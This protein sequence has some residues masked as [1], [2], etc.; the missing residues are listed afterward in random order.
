MPSLAGLRFLALAEGA[1][2]PD[3]FT[4][5]DMQTSLLDRIGRDLGNL[6][7]RVEN[8]IKRL[9]G[10]DA[11]DRALHVMGGDLEHLAEHL[12]TW[13]MAQNPEPIFALNSS[14]MPLR[15]FAA[16]PSSLRATSLTPPTSLA[17]APLA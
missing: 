15:S 13:A 6:A 14:A 7:H 12:K 1:L 9:P 11:I 8:D 16:T 10:G 17:S 4:D 3:A 2:E 5:P